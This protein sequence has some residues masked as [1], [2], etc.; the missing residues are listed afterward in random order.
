[1]SSPRPWRCFGP[2]ALILDKVFVF[3]TSVEVFLINRNTNQGEDC[4][5]H[6]RGGVSHPNRQV[7]RTRRSS[8]RP[9]RCFQEEHRGVAPD[10]VFSTSVEVFLCVSPAIIR[11]GGLLHV[12]GGVSWCP[13]GILQNKRSSPRPWR[14][15]S[16]EFAH[17]SKEIVFSTSV[18]VFLRA[19]NFPSR[20][21]GLLHVRGGVSDTTDPV[22]HDR[23]SSPRPWRCFQ[24]QRSSNVHWSVFSTSVEVF[25][26]LDAELWS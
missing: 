16:K 4:L 25:L 23:R 15:F 11:R 9:W 17:V 12:R 5:L 7:H 26:N 18:E 22:A 14:C 2:P 21:S 1:M 6:V 24:C 8:P 19:P 3:S 20:C 10:L 13:F